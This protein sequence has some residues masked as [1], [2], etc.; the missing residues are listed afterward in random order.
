MVVGLAVS[1][2][3]RSSWRREVGRQAGGHRL[4]KCLDRGQTLELVMAEISEADACA[5]RAIDSVV[6]R[7]RPGGDNGSD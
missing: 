6:G 4:K 3:D 2:H 7:S 1:K 5:L